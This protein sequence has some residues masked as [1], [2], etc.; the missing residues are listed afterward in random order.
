M[1]PLTYCDN[2]FVITAHDAPEEYKTHLRALASSGKV[3]FILSPWHWREM[4]Q[5]RITHAALPS[6]T[7]A[8]HLIL[9]GFM[10]VA[11]FK[12]GRS[13]LRSTNSQTS[14]PKHL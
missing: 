6:P 9:L 2:N 1:P 11:L 3:K 8:I 7:S 10:T 5:T 4:A 12:G 14:K 13:R